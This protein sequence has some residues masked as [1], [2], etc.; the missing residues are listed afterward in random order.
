MGL[1]TKLV[2]IQVYSNVVVINAD[3]RYIKSLVSSLK[4]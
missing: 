4:V 2:H 1:V 3:P